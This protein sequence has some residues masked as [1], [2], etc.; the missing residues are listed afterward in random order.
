[1][2]QAQLGDIITNQIFNH[3]LIG[4]VLQVVVDRFHWTE[5]ISSPG[6]F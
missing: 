5:Q 4:I 2:A 1:M 6:D 3:L